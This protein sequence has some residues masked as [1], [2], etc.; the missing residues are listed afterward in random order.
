MTNRA[1]QQQDDD[2]FDDAFENNV[3]KNGKAVR[4]SLQARDA[5]RRKARESDML[6]DVNN[7]PGTIT[8]GTGNPFGLNKPGWRIPTV[9]DR[10]AV[11]DAYET[12]E[13]ELCS[14][15]QNSVEVE[16]EC[17][18]HNSDGAT[19]RQQRDQAYLD[20]DKSISEQWR[21]PS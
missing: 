16:D 2:A 6:R 1:R 20:Y 5:N 15:W 4:V 11:R 12:Y 13:T 10:R 3:L 21:A 9:Q 8:D 7:R 17:E 14:R 18:H 19:R